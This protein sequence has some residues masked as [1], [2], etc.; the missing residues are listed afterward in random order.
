MENTFS[1]QLRKDN[2]Y[3]FLLLVSFS[4]WKCCFS[5][6]LNCLSRSKKPAKWC[7]LWL[8]R[9]LLV[10]IYAFILA[11]CRLVVCISDFFECFFLL[12]MF[13][14]SRVLLLRRMLSADGS[15]QGSGWWGLMQVYR[16][17]CLLLLSQTDTALRECVEDKT[18]W[19]LLFTS[20]S[21]LFFCL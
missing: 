4:K 3:S 7:L 20:S 15:L 8:H 1:F 16:R 17:T 14:L 18:M 12:H 6:S 21:L 13:C 9:S 19:K 10:L 2:P 5:S 11:I